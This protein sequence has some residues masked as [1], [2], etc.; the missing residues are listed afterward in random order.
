[1]AV[2]PIYRQNANYTKNT[3]DLSIAYFLAYLIYAF[4]GVI[5]YLAVFGREP[6][7]I[8]THTVIDYFSPN[9]L[10]VFVVSFLFAIFLLCVQPFLVM[11]ARG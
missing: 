5:G 8:P 6:S 9:D 2:I 1:M 11:I 10:S 7:S 4:V 3:R